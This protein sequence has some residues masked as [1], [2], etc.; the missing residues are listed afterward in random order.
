MDCEGSEYD[1][2]DNATDNT[3]L[4]FSEM[5]I[6]LHYKGEGNIVSRLRKLGYKIEM[7]KPVSRFK[8]IAHKIETLKNMNNEVY[9][10]FARR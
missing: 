6:E 7:P 5:V 9:M 2:I 10:I 8:R 1:I 3:L 4:A